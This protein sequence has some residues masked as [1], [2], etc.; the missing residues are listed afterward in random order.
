MD[1]TACVLISKFVFS[2]LPSCLD[3]IG[4]PRGEAATGVNISLIIFPF[5]TDAFHYCWPCMSN[6]FL[7]ISNS[8]LYLTPTIKDQRRIWQPIKFAPMTT[9]NGLKQDRSL[10]HRKLAHE[11]KVDCECVE[12]HTAHYWV[13]NT[14][15]IWL[16][17]LSLRIIF[18]A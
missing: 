2:S 16:L 8:D 5:L 7:N 12:E 4:P 18:G 1:H 6:W 3:S 17:V 15:R 9:V 14:S 10:I 13:N 11:H